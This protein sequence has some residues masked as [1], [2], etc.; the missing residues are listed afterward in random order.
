MPSC[1]TWP[2]TGDSELVRGNYTSFVHADER[3]LACVWDLFHRAAL[4]DESGEAT[5]ADAFARPPWTPCPALCPLSSPACRP[6]SAESAAS[7]VPSPRT[8]TPNSPGRARRRA[9]PRP[10]VLASSGPSHTR[11]DAQR[12]Q[13]AAERV[14]AGERAAAA[15]WIRMEAARNYS[16]LPNGVSVVSSS[17]VASVDSV[18]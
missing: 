7:A 16:S 1:T 10:R 12:V 9:P 5:L 15:H 17:L 14:Q 3:L 18:S 2:L 11:R 8:L 6:A 13:Q 4:D